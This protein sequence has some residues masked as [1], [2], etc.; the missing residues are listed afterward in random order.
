MLESAEAELGREK[1]VPVREK[2]AGSKRKAC[3]GRRKGEAGFRRRRHRGSNL[4]PST[5]NN[6]TLALL[7]CSN[8]V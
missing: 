6:F 5:H 1:A 3:I 7:T 2:R 4:K 8:E